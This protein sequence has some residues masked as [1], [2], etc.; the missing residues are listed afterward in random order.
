[1]LLFFKPLIFVNKISFSL[2]CL[3]YSNCNIMKT[4]K[5]NLLYLFGLLT[6]GQLTFAQT[7]FNEIL[8]ID[9]ENSMTTEAETT[10]APVDVLAVLQEVMDEQQ[11]IGEIT[12]DIAVLLAHQIE[13]ED[14]FAEVLEEIDL[15][16]QAI[17]EALARIYRCSV[18][19]E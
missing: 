6:F 9:T 12:T 18:G 10:S 2:I 1:M 5:L 7:S 3:D 15:P 4:I 8:P 14:Y 19:I 11:T 17:L 16:H 13:D